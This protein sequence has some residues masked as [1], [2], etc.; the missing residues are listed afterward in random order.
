KRLRDLRSGLEVPVGGNQAFDPLV[1][2]LEVV[3]VD[4]VADPLPGVVEP[5]E[6]G[7]LKALSP[8]RPPEPLDLAERLRVPRPC[9]DVLDASLLEK[10][11][12]G[13]LAPPRVVLR[14]VI[15]EDLFG[16]SEVAD[17]CVESFSHEGP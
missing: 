2:P 9:D 17:P 6:H 7:F 5:D 15:G 8:E 4:E 14:A 12:K 1:R 10:L 3:M 11:R 16:G 13:A